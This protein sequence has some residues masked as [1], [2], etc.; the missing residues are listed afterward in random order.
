MGIL[1]TCVYIHI[2]VNGLYVGV[3]MK[4]LTHVRL[5]PGHVLEQKHPDRT[6]AL[7][8]SGCRQGF[9]M[10]HLGSQDKPT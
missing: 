9:P 2:H 6:Q 1:F 7:E 4:T 8:L 3:C 5:Y 10:E